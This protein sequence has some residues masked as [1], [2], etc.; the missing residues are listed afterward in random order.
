[1]KI[2]RERTEACAWESTAWAQ[3]R[4]DI[5]FAAKEVSAKHHGGESGKKMRAGLVGQAENS[6][7]SR[8][9]IAS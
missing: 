6:A 4:R 7:E 3:G 5:S 1:M 9:A 8:D 2:I